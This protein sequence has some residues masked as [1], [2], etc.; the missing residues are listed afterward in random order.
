MSR[1]HCGD[2]TGRTRHRSIA[3]DRPAPARYPTRFA[4]DLPHPVSTAGAGS[5]T[6]SGGLSTWTYSIRVPTAVSLSFHASQVDFPGGAVLKVTGANGTSATYRAKGIGRSGLWSR[7]LA[8]D[9]LVLSLTVS[10]AAR[11]QTDLEIESFQAGYRS[12]G[13]GVPDNPHFRKS[14]A[15][16]R[17]NRQ[18]LHRELRVRNQ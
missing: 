16:G 2:G 8:G 1:R 17:A 10:A 3:A 6:Q 13:P 9:S 12:L 18:R 5:W 11:P 7:P 4:V 14:R 15:K